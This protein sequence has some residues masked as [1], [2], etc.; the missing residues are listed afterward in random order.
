MRKIGEFIINNSEYILGAI[1]A[2]IIPTLTYLFNFLRNK[3]KRRKFKKLLIK[4]YINP[5]KTEITN[6]NIEHEFVD[7]QNKLAKQLTRLTYLKKEEINYINN[8]NQFYYI[9][10][11]EYTKILLS[12]LHTETG[13]YEYRSSKPTEKEQEQ[14]EEYTKNKKRRMLELMKIYEEDFDKY[15]KLEIDH[16]RNS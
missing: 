7:Y 16:L 5:I 9:R 10:S 1:T 2:I 3:I 13:K 6:K 15:T 14:E 8:N 4:D 11:I 12:S